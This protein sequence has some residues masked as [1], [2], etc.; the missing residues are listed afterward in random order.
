MWPWTNPAKELKK[1]LD[2]ADL[3]SAKSYTHEEFNA[4]VEDLKT[5]KL[6]IFERVTNFIRFKSYDA[7]WAVYRFFK[8]CHKRLRK[9]IPRHWVDLSEV[10][11]LVNFE[12]IKSYVEEEMNSTDWTS[13]EKHKEVAE[14][15]NTAYNYITKERPQLEKQLSEAFANIDY[16]VTAPY[17]EKYK[18]VI[19]I[20][21]L[22]E[23]T[24]ENTLNKLAKYRLFL[25]S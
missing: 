4:F 11:L 24:D 9:A 1:R 3:S 25:W 5:R 8:P 19:R 23:Q 22:I 2:E 15:L 6:S 16:K 20:E 18:E 12:I 21:N 10:T 17:D 7:S 13:D 14:W